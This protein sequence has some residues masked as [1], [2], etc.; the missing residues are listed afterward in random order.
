MLREIN[1]GLRNLVNF[2]GRDA[3][4][5]FWL[6][7]LFVY[8][9]GMAISAVVAL[10]LMAG[11]VSGAF[12]AVRAAGHD[13]KAVQAAMN[14]VVATKMSAVLS[15]IVLVSALVAVLHVLL[16]AAALVRRLHDSNL[17][18]W[19]AL[20][21]V[22]LQGAVLAHMPAQLA[23]TRAMMQQTQN[24]MPSTAAAGAGVNGVAGLLGWLVI[25][26]VVLIGTRK[27]TV[28]ANDYGDAQVS[29]R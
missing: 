4:Q 28:G 7:V 24:G 21:P 22:A 25:L 27:S 10:P 12:D 14:N 23:T 5:T 9:L 8:L 17:P 26:I 15:Q 6:F 19:L 1:H 16:L 13:P 11:I 18:G 29:L 20:I 3:R 2:Q